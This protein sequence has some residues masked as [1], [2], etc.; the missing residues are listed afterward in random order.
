MRHNLILGLLLLSSVGAFANRIDVLKNEYM[1][2]FPVLIECESAQTVPF[3]VNFSRWRMENSSPDRMGIF[4]K[5]IG[6]RGENL[7]RPVSP[8]SEDALLEGNSISMFL[9][10]SF[11]MGNIIARDRVL[12]LTY[13][14]PLTAPIL[15]YDSSAVFEVALYPPL[16]AYVDDSVSISGTAAITRTES[17]PFEFVGYRVEYSTVEDTATF[18]HI[19]ETM[20]EQVRDGELCRFSTL[21]LDVGYYIVRLWYIFS[22]YGSVDS[23][24][25]DNTLY[26]NYNAKVKEKYLPDEFCLLTYPNPFNSSCVIFVPEKAKVEICDSRGHIVESIS[27]E[28]TNGKFVWTPSETQPSGIYFVRMLMADGSDI[29]RKIL[30]LR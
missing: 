6:V 3:D 23:V 7:S 17:A 26:L 13:N 16:S 5:K 4:L 21:G 20:D 30:Y 19:T 15:V 8:M 25:F 29:S 14:T 12:A 18:F 11:V 9:L 1:R 28:A 10:T 24:A 27:G 2:W 22:S